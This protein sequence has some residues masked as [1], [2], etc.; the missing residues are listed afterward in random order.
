MQG[1]VLITPATSN[2]R[3][4]KFRIINE[5]ISAR[6]R[7]ILPGFP[8]EFRFDST[9][10]VRA[11]LA[12]DRIQ[13]LLCG[14]SLKSMSK[15]LTIHGISPRDYKL[16]FGIPLTYGLTSEES[17]KKYQ[18]GGA[19]SSGANAENRARFDAAIDYEKRASAPD[20]IRVECTERLHRWRRTNGQIGVPDAP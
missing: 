8:K 14:R 3:R 5:R 1:P 4:G 18:A 20:F 13:C 17:R 19:L 11:Y 7:Q 15:H 6:R 10:E 12:G 9:N 16:R 2:R